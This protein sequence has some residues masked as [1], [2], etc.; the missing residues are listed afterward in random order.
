[1]VFVGWVRS[2]EFYVIP[3]LCVGL[4]IPASIISEFGICS[5][6]QVHLFLVTFVSSFLITPAVMPA[7][8]LESASLAIQ[9]H[10]KCCKLQTVGYWQQVTVFFQAASAKQFM[11]TFESSWQQNGIYQAAGAVCP[12]L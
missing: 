7:N 2:M 6:R 4:H 10:M 9:L 3:L 8:I 1:M 5:E 11:C 12:F